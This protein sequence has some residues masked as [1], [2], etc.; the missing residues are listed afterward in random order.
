[1]FR[2][3][4]EH[5]IDDKGRLSI[6]AKLREGAVRAEQISHPASEYE[7]NWERYRRELRRID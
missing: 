1:M 7:R 5:A 6:P 3:Q 2:G 4:Y